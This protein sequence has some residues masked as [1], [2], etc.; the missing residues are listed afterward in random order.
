[1]GVTVPVSPLGVGKQIS[2]QQFPGDRQNCDLVGERR[3]M[4]I[5]ASDFDLASEM[6]FVF[7]FI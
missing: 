4:P 1:M 2:P 7:L 5:E 3:K 6:I